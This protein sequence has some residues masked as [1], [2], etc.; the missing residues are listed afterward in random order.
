MLRN[1]KTKSKLLLFPL[2]FIIII[3]IFAFVYI[4]YSNSANRQNEVYS[5]TDELIRTQKENMVTIFK[6][7]KSRY[8]K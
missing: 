3:S 8:T 1:I 4:H 7:T 2:G 5:K 6:S